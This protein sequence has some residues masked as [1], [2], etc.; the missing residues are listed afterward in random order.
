MDFTHAYT[1]TCTR[2]ITVVHII[3][4]HT[5]SCMH[6]HAYVYTHLFF[7]FGFFNWGGKPLRSFLAVPQA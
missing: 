7:R 3:T 6:G 1:Y 5:L 2:N 4:K